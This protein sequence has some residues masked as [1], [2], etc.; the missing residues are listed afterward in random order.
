MR[1]LR[2]IYSP[3]ERLS[4]VHSGISAVSYTYTDDIIYVL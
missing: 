4:C 2:N 1:S 3:D